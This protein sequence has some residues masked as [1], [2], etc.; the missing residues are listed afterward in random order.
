MEEMDFEDDFIDTW[1]QE[2]KDEDDPPASEP[3]H[4]GAKEEE[5]DPEPLQP[6]MVP[7]VF[8][9]E[10]KLNTL[11]QSLSH[12]ARKSNSKVNQLYSLLFCVCQDCELLLGRNRPVIPFSMAAEAQAKDLKCDN[13]VMKH[14][15]FVDGYCVGD[16]ED[17]EIND[18]FRFRMGIIN[19]AMKPVVENAVTTLKDPLVRSHN[20]LRAI[21]Q[22]IDDLKKTNHELSVQTRQT[23]NRL[24]RI[25]KQGKDIDLQGNTDKSD[26]LIHQQ[27][28][29]KVLARVYNLK[30][31][32]ETTVTE[33]SELQTRIA[34]IT[35]KNPKKETTVAPRIAELQKR[36]AIV[37]ASNEQ[38]QEERETALAQRRVSI[39][40]MNDSIRKLEREISIMTS[41]TEE[42]DN[43]IR[44]MT[45]GKREMPDRKRVTRMPALNR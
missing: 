27:R 38:S 28:L 43:K 19:R 16:G 40:R 9:Q 10:E 34:E 42:V 24:V 29:Q 2:P 22:K 45:Q 11:R 3:A 25:E 44:V 35:S 31:A 17:A 30:D 14:K 33:N 39:G 1:D 41:L 23:A 26:V 6:V 12:S 32:N 18:F 21:N 36:I 20:R 7:D 15:K 8:E 13:G 4:L 5:E 37:T